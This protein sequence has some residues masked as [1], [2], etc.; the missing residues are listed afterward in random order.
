MPP[1][2]N[3]VICFLNDAVSTVAFSHICSSVG[4]LRKNKFAPVSKFAT[5]QSPLAFLSLLS[6]RYTTILY[7]NLIGHVKQLKK[8]VNFKKHSSFIFQF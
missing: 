5:P 6:T 1:R 8:M 4:G 2:Y 7:V 3:G